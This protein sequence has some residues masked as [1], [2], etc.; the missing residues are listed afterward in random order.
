MAGF[1]YCTS[2]ILILLILLP[3]VIASAGER[4]SELTA[5]IQKQ[6]QTIESFR[7]QFTQK[8]INASSKDSEEREGWIAYRRP[9][10]IHWETE[11]P[12]REVL[13][14]NRD[15]VWDYYPE[16]N[17]AYRYSLRQMFDSKT[18]LRFISGDVDLAQEFN[19]T[20]MDSGSAEGTLIRL[21]LMPKNPDPSLVQAELRVD[22]EDMLIR[23]IKLID[24]FGN[25]NILRFENFQR[26][27]Q[28]DPDLF[29]L[30]PPE[31]TRVVDR[32]GNGTTGGGEE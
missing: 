25:Q 16:E 12:E 6:Y 31:E 8:L 29:V 10:R 18:M 30:D 9:R 15:F 22:P 7:T 4:E 17:V 26:N 11:S 3:P 19:V 20:R 23:R 14:L 27:C 2:L 32:A 21:K 28:P 24:F 13:I 5:A 1:R